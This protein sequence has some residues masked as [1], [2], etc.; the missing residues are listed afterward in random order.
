[1]ATAT[2]IIVKPSSNFFEEWKLD[3]I[4][5]LMTPMTTSSALLFEGTIDKNRLEQA[6]Q[7]TADA[8]PWMYCS[9]NV[10]DNGDVYVVQ[11]NEE[12]GTNENL[13]GGYCRCEIDDHS[14]ISKE[15]T[16]EII[17][18]KELLPVCIHE[19]MIRIDLAL[20]SVDELPICALRVTQFAN[21]FTFGYRLNHAFYDQSAIVYLFT[22]LS[23]VYT[24]NGVPTIVPPIFKSRSNIVE[25]GNEFTSDLDFV[26]AA[27][28]G[29]TVEP[30]TG[31]S[32]SPSLNL[33][34]TLNTEKVSILKQESTDTEAQ[35]SSND[36]LHAIFLKA[37]SKYHASRSSSSDIEN[38]EN[39]LSLFFARDMRNP[40]G[41]GREITGDYVR[42]ESF[43]SSLLTVITA[44]ILELAQHNRRHIN[45]A[46]DIQRYARECLWFMDFNKFRPDGS[47]PNSD[48]L[49]DDKSVVVT[50]WSSFAYENIVFDSSIACELLAEPSSHATPT[51]CFVKVLFQRIGKQRKISASIS[52]LYPELIEAFRELS[53][54]SDG[55]FSCL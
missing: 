46:I 12:A 2:E 31:L 49:T 37:I 42:L 34:I 13:K 4:S 38:N 33:V 18:I 24:N 41:F 22:F 9:F 52:T 39:L 20:I 16:P 14:S 48:F 10:K 21:H 15:Y 1:M 6:I 19:K 32:F 47:R 26:N 7:I 17:K 54:E 35:L 11:R 36:I 28:A 5:K 29:Y 53:H 51:G 23:N 27:P 43:T 40:L 44:S 8:Y 55:L 25:T 45:Q 50:N 3:E 30:L